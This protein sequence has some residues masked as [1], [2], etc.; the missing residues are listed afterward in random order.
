MLKRKVK[1]IL[2]LIV[3]FLAILSFIFYFVNKH[4]LSFVEIYPYWIFIWFGFGFTVSLYFIATYFL[5]GSKIIIFILSAI[6]TLL[7]EILHQFC[8]D[9]HSNSSYSQIVLDLT[10]ILLAAV[11]VG[12]FEND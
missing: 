6:I 2:S 1:N 11:F 12:Y 9:F 3:I 10:G 5:H 8:A 7:I 4:I